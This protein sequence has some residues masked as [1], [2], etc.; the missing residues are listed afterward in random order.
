MMT[1]CW[2]CAN[3]VPDAEGEMMC[4]WDETERFC[5]HKRRDLGG[6]PKHWLPRCHSLDAPPCTA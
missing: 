4:G 2:A 3:A 6:S 1:I 5:T